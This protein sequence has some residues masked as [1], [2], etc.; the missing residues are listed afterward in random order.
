MI[1]LQQSKE[2]QSRACFIVHEHEGLTPDFVETIVALLGKQTKLYA[3]VDH[4]GE[5][6]KWL[7]DKGIYC[8]A[9]PQYLAENSKGAGKHAENIGNFFLVVD[10]LESYHVERV[11]IERN[12]GK[13]LLLERAFKLKAPACEEEAI[14]DYLCLT[15]L[16][17]N[18]KKLSNLDKRAGAT[19]YAI[20]RAQERYPHCFYLPVKTTLEGI[21][22]FFLLILFTPLLL[23]LLLLNMGKVK[24]RAVLSKANSVRYIKVFERLNCE[25]SEKLHGWW[26]LPSLWNV[27]KGDLALIGPRIVMP[28]AEIQP[29]EL[30]YQQA[31]GLISRSQLKAN[32]ELSTAQLDELDQ[33]YMHGCSP[34]LDIKI[35]LLAAS[36]ILKLKSNA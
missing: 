35:M 17:L 3:L 33:A 32:N 25:E 9:F 28:S 6:S 30:Y 1:L 8:F 14:G 27:C 10:F 19:F 12:S 13:K 11:V 26:W 20:A 18:E 24:S 15:D 2:M 16:H 34:L 36:K 21:I 29:S 22:S 31:P 7:A 5:A 4:F 23:F